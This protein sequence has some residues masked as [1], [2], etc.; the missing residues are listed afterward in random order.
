LE[1]LCLLADRDMTVGAIVDALG[2]SPSSASQQ[3]MRLR[4]EGLVSATRE[5]RSVTYRIERPEVRM[6]VTTL[7]SAF[8]RRPDRRDAG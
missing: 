5:G 8:G 1:I 3:L 7:K 2:L 6:V 4:A